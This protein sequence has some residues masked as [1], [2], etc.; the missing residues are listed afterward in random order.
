MRKAESAHAQYSFNG[1]IAKNPLGRMD[2]YISRLQAAGGTFD[3][4]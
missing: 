3:A 4:D 2:D 1:V